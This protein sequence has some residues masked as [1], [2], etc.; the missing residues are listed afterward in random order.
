MFIWSY[1]IPG[2]IFSFIS[3]DTKEQ[4]ARQ[5]DSVSDLITIILVTMKRDNS[6][7]LKSFGT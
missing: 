2:G 5:T 4:R 3:F 1:E 7:Y 6:T